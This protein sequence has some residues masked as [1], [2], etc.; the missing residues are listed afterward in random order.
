MP[1]T[2]HCGRPSAHENGDC[3]L[4]AVGKRTAKYEYE[5]DGVH[6]AW[7]CT[8]VRKLTKTIRVIEESLATARNEL[9]IARGP[10]PEVALA[11]LHAVVD[12]ARQVAGTDITLWREAH[13]QKL[14]DALA[15][16]ARLDAGVAEEET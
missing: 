4:C 14:R 5:Y 3:D 8:A 7:L 2:C 13:V 1:T 16:L 9:H 15:R 10:H 12:A 11:R 6:I